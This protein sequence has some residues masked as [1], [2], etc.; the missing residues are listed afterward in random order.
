[1]TT[2]QRIAQMIEPTVKALGFELV[3]VRFGGGQKAILQ[4]MAERPD[5]TFTIEDCESLSRDISA[6]LDVEDPIH[7][8]YTLEVSS[9]GIDR[10]LVRPVDF[11]RYA[12]FLTKLTATEQVEGRRRFT[13]VLKGISEDHMITLE[14]DEGTFKIPFDRMEKAKLVLTDA[15][16]KAHQ[17]AVK[18]A[19]TMENH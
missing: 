4:I 12:G 14:C 5:G 18:A 11:D 16:I 8:E 9:P 3:R 19:P 17:D 2:Q 1:M 13:G 10:P 6:V 15:L 7:E